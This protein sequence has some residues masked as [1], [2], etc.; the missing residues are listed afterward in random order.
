M[1]V[2]LSIMAFGDAAALPAGL[3]LL[4]DT[5][6]L[7]GLTACFVSKEDGSVVKAVGG[8]ALTMVKNPLLLSVVA[9]LLFAASGLNL[10]QVALNLMDLLANAAPPVALLPLAQRCTGEN[11]AASGR[12]AV[13]PCSNLL[14]IRCL[15]PVF[16]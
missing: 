13:S 3:I 12:S 14:C 6:V 1:G 16:S 9:G 15:W 8:I 5:I 11:S 10:P 7:L 4:A 2:P